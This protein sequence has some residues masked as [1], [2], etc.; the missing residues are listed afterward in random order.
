MEILGHRQCIPDG[1]RGI[2]TLVSNLR[3]HRVEPYARQRECHPNTTLGGQILKLGAAS[4]W[5]LALLVLAAPVA[6]ADAD[7]H[8]PNADA[9]WCPGGVYQE[10]LSGGTKYCLGI[11]FSTG[12]FYAQGWAGNVFPFRPGHW[13]ESAMCSVMVEGLIQGGIPYGGDPDCD[14][15]PKFISS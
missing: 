11:P 12:A 3:Q 2:E 7:P 9:G 14:G 1:K 4:L 5:S 13:Q 8:V 15:G 6:S 10:K